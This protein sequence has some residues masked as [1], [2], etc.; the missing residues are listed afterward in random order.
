MNPKAE[1]NP[2]M[3]TL[4]SRVKALYFIDC[5]FP[6]HASFHEYEKK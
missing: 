1:K 2:G 4:K 6:F 5:L 3:L